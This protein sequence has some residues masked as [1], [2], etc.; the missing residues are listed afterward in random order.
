M[1]LGLFAKLESLFGLG[2]RLLCLNLGVE[3]PTTG[4]LDLLCLDLILYAR[5][6]V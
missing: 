3:N 2:L 6:M 1:A 4:R 5:L